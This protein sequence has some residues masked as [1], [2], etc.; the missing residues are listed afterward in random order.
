MDTDKKAYDN[1]Y[2]H[3]SRRSRKRNTL[4]PNDC[5]KLPG[6]NSVTW[7]IKINQLTSEPYQQKLDPL[8]QVDPKK[9]Q[10]ISERQKILPWSRETVQAEGMANSL[11][12]KSDLP[13]IVV[14][15]KEI[16]PRRNWQVAY[17]RKR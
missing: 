17:Q 1:R 10:P 7:G 3:P 14:D 9:L 8:N 2:K 13:W 6:A 11:R 15:F 12:R 5:L 16:N 4:Q